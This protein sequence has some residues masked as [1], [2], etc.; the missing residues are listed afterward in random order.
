MLPSCPAMLDING[1][2]ITSKVFHNLVDAYTRPLYMS[3]VQKKF[4]WDDTTVKAIA[5]DSLS[6]ALNRIDRPVLM[7][8]ISN[9]LLPTK[10]FIYSV[11]HIAN[12]HEHMS[13]MQA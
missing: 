1:I 12:I 10:S 5:W 6:L 7:T 11:Q 13:H 3:C 4:E 8:K 9:N 2:S